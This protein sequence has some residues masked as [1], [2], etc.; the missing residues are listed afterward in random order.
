MKIW[1]MLKFIKKNNHQLNQ[2]VIG[3]QIFYVIEPNVL[4][5]IIVDRLIQ[6]LFSLTIPLYWFSNY[7][8]F[9]EFFSIYNSNT[10]YN[11][12]LIY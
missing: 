5:S 6:K 3:N 10:M 8:E 9:E 12:I 7:Y 2:I 1:D 4:D 11:F